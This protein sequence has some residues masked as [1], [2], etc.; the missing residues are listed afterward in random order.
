MMHTKQTTNGQINKLQNTRHKFKVKTTKYTKLKAR[1][2]TSHI[3]PADI[4][5]CKQFKCL[6][7]CFNQGKEEKMK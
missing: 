3:C 1:C 7:Q 2:D 6:V 5:Q 4:G